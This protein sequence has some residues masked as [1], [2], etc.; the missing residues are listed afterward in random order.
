MRG[1]LAA[2]DGALFVPLDPAQLA[3]LLDTFLLAK[4]FH[5]L[6]DGLR[7]LRHYGERSATSIALDGLSA[8]L[9]LNGARA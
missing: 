9:D 5:E 2:T 1:Y 6:E 3:L 4:A 8:L 7:V